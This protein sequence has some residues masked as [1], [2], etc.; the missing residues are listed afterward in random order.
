M[1][2]GVL[3]LRYGGDVDSHCRRDDLPN[4]KTCI[5]EKTPKK[6]HKRTIKE[7]AA[8]I[9]KDKQTR[10]ATTAVAVLENRAEEGAQRVPVQGKGEAAKLPLKNERTL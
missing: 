3:L 5:K 4:C 2:R 8:E 9:A 1:A 10:K 7:K 6:K